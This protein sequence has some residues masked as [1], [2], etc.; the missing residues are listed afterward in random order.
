MVE[1]LSKILDEMDIPEQRKDVK[2]KRNLNWLVKNLWINNRHHK[3]F[4]LAEELI[5]N[6]IR[7][8]K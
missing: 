8:N 4:N 2:K 3:H 5:V 7:Y 1:L 6:L